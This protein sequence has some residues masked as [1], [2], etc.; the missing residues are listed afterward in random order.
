MGN[1]WMEI[2]EYFQSQHENTTRQGAL[3]KLNVVGLG[4]D[5]VVLLRC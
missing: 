3:T 5:I 1:I 4:R 2:L